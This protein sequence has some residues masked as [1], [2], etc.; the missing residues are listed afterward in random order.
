M[1]VVVWL[2][3]L[4]LGKYEAIFREND[5][6]EVVLPSDT[7]PSHP[8]AQSFRPLWCSDPLKDGQRFSCNWLLRL[9][10]GL[11]TITSFHGAGRLLKLL[12]RPIRLKNWVGK[13]CGIACIRLRQFDPK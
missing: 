9:A 2:R 11:L 8:R 4:G 5:I 13:G 3:S 10:R 12:H 6:D 1:D 7:M